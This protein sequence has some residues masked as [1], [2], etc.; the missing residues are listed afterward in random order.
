MKVVSGKEKRK[1]GYF[2]HMLSTVRESLKLPA[3][4]ASYILVYDDS[5]VEFGS[6][7]LVY[8]DSVVAFQKQ[9]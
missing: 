6:C 8:A 3:T 2:P 1:R 9:D 4:Q 5:A 7:I